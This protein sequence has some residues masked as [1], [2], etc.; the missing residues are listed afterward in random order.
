VALQSQHAGFVVGP[1]PN[2]R[3]MGIEASS[4]PMS[5]LWDPGSFG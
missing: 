1:D 2:A 5:L 3:L 4:N